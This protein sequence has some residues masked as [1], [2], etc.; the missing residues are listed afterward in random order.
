MTF[1]H[2]TLTGSS[3]F[4]YKVSPERPNLTFF[5]LLR[6]KGSLMATG[7]STLCFSVPPTPFLNPRLATLQT[8]RPSQPCCP[9]DATNRN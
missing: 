3:P 6:L 8:E 1:T 4:L 7:D 2:E 5:L 9:P